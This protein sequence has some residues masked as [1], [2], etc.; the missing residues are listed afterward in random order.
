MRMQ[1][2][3]IQHSKKKHP[4]SFWNPYSCCTE[5]SRRSS[6][7]S[8][9]RKCW[10]K[11]QSLVLARLKNHRSS[12]GCFSQAKSNI[13]K[14]A[15]SSFWNLIL[16]VRKTPCRSSCSSSRRNVEEKSHPLFLAD[17]KNHRQCMWMQAFQDAIPRTQHYSR[18]CWKNS[19]EVPVA[20]LQ[21]MLK[22]K[23]HHLFIKKI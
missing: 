12:C 20:V 8:S 23:H 11:N 7:S 13:P 19:V 17:S 21:K 15:S 22:K 2:L 16:A 6:C 14:K 5:N 4:A 9:R 3:K 1:A 10:R 18:H